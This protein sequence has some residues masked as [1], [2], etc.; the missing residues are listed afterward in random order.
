MTLCIIET[1]YWL[2][3][4]LRAWEDFCCR[5]DGIYA[6][7]ILLSKDCRSKNS[8]IHYSKQLSRIWTLFRTLRPKT[9]LNLGRKF[10]CLK[11]VWWRTKLQLLQKRVANIALEWWV[12][13]YQQTT[14]SRKGF[15]NHLQRTVVGLCNRIYRTRMLRNSILVKESKAITMPRC[16]SRRKLWLSES[17]W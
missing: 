2:R 7:D 10:G 16:T 1:S 3:A 5:K 8:L 9:S 15:P 11:K 17:A 14:L 13:N 4:S 6:A 12:A